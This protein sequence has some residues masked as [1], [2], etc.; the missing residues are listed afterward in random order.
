MCLCERCGSRSWASSAGSS[1]ARPSTEPGCGERCG[2]PGAE[3]GLACWRLPGDRLAAPGEG[4]PRVGGRHHPRRD[5]P[6]GR[7]GVLRQAGRRLPRLG[8]ALQIGLGEPDKRLRCLVLE[9]PRSVALG[10]EPVRIDGEVVGRV[11]SGG[12]GY[13]VKRSIA[14]AYL[15]GERRD[16]CGRRGGHLRR[17]GSA[18]RLPTSRCSTPRVSASAPSEDDASQRLR[19]EPQSRIEQTICSSSSG[20]HGIGEGRRRSGRRPSRTIT[21]VRRQASGAASRV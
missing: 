3:H 20:G 11:T 8:A 18:A 9:D 7:A 16:R 21:R 19:R 14:Y 4:L 6:R 12:Y 13:T 2:R 1:T 5:A 15:P 17:S 10:N